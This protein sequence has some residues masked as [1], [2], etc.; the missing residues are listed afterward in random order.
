MLARQVTNLTGFGAYVVAWRGFA[1]I[2]RVKMCAGTG[3]VAIGRDRV[4][5]DVVH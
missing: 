1:T 4:H 3:A 2:S 5:V